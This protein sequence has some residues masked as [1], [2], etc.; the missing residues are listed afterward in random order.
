MGA[1]MIKRSVSTILTAALVL[2]AGNAALAADAGTVTFATGSVSAERQPAA[3]L[4][5]GDTVLVE[6]FVITGAASRAQLMM[7]DGAKVAIRPNSRLKIEEYVYATA[8]PASGPAVVTTSNDNSSVIS[9]VKGGFRTIT[10]AIGKEDPADYGVRTAVGVLGIR[11]TDFAALFCVGDCNAAPG[12]TPGTIVPDGLYLMVT[13][14]SIEFSNEVAN[15]VLTAGQFAFIPLDTRRATRLATTP[16]VFI[17]DSDF[18]FVAESSAPPPDGSASPPEDDGSS[19][20]GF[21]EKLGTRRAPDSSAPESDSTE[22]GS[23]SGRDTPTQSIQGI[24]RDG[25]PVDLTPGNSPDPGNRS[26]SYSTGP[27]GA[28]DTIFSG[29]M[30]NSPGQYQLDGS[31]ALTGFDNVYPARTAAGPATYDIGTASIGESGFDSMTVMR[32]GRWAGGAAAITLSDG[33]DAS[34]DLG[35]QSIHWISS[36]EWAAPPVMPIM[37]IANYTL[38]GS[39]SP[40]D[41]LGNTGVLGAA[42]FQADF[43]RMLVDSTL[44]IDINGATWTAAGQGDIGAIALLPAHLFLGDY[45]A[46]AIDGV[47]GGTG[48][49]SGFFSQPGATSDP[50]YPGGAGLTY[51]LQ[52]S[53]GTITVSG[54]AAF[55]NP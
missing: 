6:D 3:A 34:Q 47:T 40:T 54:A 8:A 15:L 45:T 36:P 35:T 9:L 4:A 50:S 31:N 17:D 5:R 25:A 43:T 24:D 44:I 11:G 52:D 41:N 48:V 2:A 55:G 12:V 53:G 21:D 13:E 14:G 19:P 28:I 32:W 1:K 38:I 51:S 42:T 37:G 22:Q 27:L 7:I 33:T 29:V 16:P 10:G 26:I 49:F 23:G 46:V 30:D 20:L 39:T 18:R